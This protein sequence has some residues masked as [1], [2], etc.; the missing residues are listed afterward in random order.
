MTT[1]ASS[2]PL[3]TVEEFYTLTDDAM[4]HELLLGRLLSEPPPGYGHGRVVTRISSRLDHHAS[5]HDLGEVVSGD[6]GFI[7]SRAPDTV[8]APDVAFVRKERLARFS[9][10]EKYFP[11]APDLAVEVLSPSERTNTIHGKVADYLA[12]GTRMVWVIDSEARTVS[13]Y[14]SLLSPRVLALGQELSGEDVLPGFSL[15]VAHLFTD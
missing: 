7:L 13:V 10:R 12:A 3:L 11:G 4:R 14:H 8:R 9:D 1:H 5:A 2:Q 15:E 6:V